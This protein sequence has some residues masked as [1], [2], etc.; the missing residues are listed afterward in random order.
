MHI[1]ERLAKFGGDL[2]LGILPLG[3]TQRRN[4]KLVLVVMPQYRKEPSSI[5]VRQ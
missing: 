1:L 5:T 3:V 4:S 2:M